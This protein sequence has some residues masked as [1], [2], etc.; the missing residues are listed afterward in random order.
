MLKIIT[1]ASFGFPMDVSF[2][3]GQKFPRKWHLF[4]FPGEI[5]K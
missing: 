4:P 3:I 1:I 5:L 2:N